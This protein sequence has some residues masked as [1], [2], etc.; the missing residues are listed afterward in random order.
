MG[1][2]IPGYGE[3]VVDETIELQWKALV[4]K[5]VRPAC[6][7]LCLVE[8]SLP[9]RCLDPSFFARSFVLIVWLVVCAQRAKGTFG[10]TMAIVDV[11]GTLL[12]SSSLYRA[13]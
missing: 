4:D 10:R 8:V 6:F 1:K 2:N 11:S 13:S 12:C 3:V 9:S 7:L 5:L